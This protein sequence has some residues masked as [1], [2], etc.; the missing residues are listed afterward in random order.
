MNTPDSPA[1]QRH[2]AA[3]LLKLF[4]PSILGILIFFVPIDIGGETTIL[5]DHMV[6]GA[7]NLL[8]HASGFYA[9]TLIVAGAAL[10]DGQQRC[11][12]RAGGSARQTYFG[13]L[14]G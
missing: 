8:G 6:T 10:A 11:G 2:G 14:S 5:L 7:R 12:W 1:R 9:L 4:L 3:T 13:I